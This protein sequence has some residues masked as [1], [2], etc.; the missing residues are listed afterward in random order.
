MS[1]HFNVEKEF[2]DHGYV[3][4]VARL[5]RVSGLG[6]RCG[7][8]GIPASHA[9]YGKAY[10]QKSGVPKETTKVNPTDPIGTLLQAMSADDEISI[11]YAA[12]VHGGI[13]YAGNGKGAYPIEKPDTWWFGFDCAHCDDN[14]DGGQSLEY[15]IEECKKL[16]KFL[17]AYEVKE[18]I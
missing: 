8:V 3:C 15:C 9:L 12:Q 7:Y 14:E 17:A 13:T 6:H 4:V 1:K 5:N 10:D 2:E 11:S 16:A 18:V